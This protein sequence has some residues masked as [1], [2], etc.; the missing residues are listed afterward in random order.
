VT[1]SG[2]S[3]TSE[4]GGRGRKHSD[5]ARALTIEPRERQRTGAIGQIIL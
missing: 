2:A 5:L 1:D 3:A 4:R